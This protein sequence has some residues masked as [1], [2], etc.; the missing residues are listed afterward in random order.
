M[1]EAKSTENNRIFKMDYLT[2][3]NIY[4]NLPLSVHTA[5]NVIFFTTSYVIFKRN[6]H[7]FKFNL[8]Y[9]S[10]YWGIFLISNTLFF[11]SSGLLLIGTDFLNK[12]S[13]NI[14]KYYKIVDHE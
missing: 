7:Y 8:N 6:S 2:N 12:Y 11:F 4:T 1:I 10:K 9:Y 13:R 3:K 5:L 14:R